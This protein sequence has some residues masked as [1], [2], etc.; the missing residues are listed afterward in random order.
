MPSKPFEIMKMLEQ[1][2]LTGR[3]IHNV[4]ANRDVTGDE[5]AI[6]QCG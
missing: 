6:D 3:Y 2:R 4:I 1:T 5:K